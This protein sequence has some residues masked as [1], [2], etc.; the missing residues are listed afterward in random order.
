MDIVH[1]S[2]AESYRS[3]ELADI[4]PSKCHYCQNETLFVD[5]CGSM[6]HT[7]GFDIECTQTQTVK[8]LRSRAKFSIDEMAVKTGFTVQQI[9]LFENTEPSSEYLDVF[10]EVIQDNYRNKYKE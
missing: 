1:Q 9:T 7:C 10:R 4:P 6:C 8:F 5:H 3:G 2:T